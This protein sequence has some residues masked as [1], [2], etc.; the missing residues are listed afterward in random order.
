MKN[1]QEGACTN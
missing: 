1:L